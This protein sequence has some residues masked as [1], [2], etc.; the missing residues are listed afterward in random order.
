[1]KF[2][3]A[4]VKTPARSMV[5]GITSARLGAPDYEKALEQHHQYVEA[6][7]GLGVHV[8]VMDADERFPD[9]CFVEDC[10]VLTEKCA[11]ITNPGA[12]SRK[13]ETAAVEEALKEFYTRFEYIKDPGT[14]DGGDVMRVEDHFYTG[15]S[16]RTND[17]GADQFE[18]ILEGCGFTASRVLLKNVLHLKTGVV[19]LDAGN[20]VAAGEF[21]NKSAF[22]D[23]NRIIV[24][25]DEEYAANCIWVNGAVIV[26]AGYK[27]TKRS[28]EQAGYPAVETDVSEFRKLDGGLSCLSLRF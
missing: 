25:P 10:A 9:S 19:S 28:I 4:I 1:M 6:L 26:P 5:H 18:K 20:L 13:G 3:N 17:R 2:T 24:E 8:T 21:I 15:I 27:K 16:E 12:P 22:D 23:F 7:Q 11:I 14:L